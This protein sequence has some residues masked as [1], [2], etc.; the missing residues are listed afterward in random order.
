MEWSRSGLESRPCLELLSWKVDVEWCGFWFPESPPSSPSSGTDVDWETVVAGLGLVGKLPICSHSATS[1]YKSVKVTGVFLLL[2]IGSYLCYKLYKVW[3]YQHFQRIGLAR[4]DDINPSSPSSFAEGTPAFSYHHSSKTP[5]TVN[6]FLN[7]QTR[8]FGPVNGNDDNYSESE[9][10][11]CHDFT[12]AAVGEQS[13]WRQ[14]P[15]ERRRKSKLS[16]PPSVNSRKGWLLQR[17]QSLTP[18][19]LQ[20]GNNNEDKCNNRYSPRDGN[21]TGTSS[22]NSSPMSHT[23]H[24]V[25]RDLSFDSLGLFYRTRREGSIDSMSSELSFDMPSFTEQSAENPTVTRLDKLQEEIDQLKSN[26]QLMD[27]EFETVKCNRN[28]PG[29]SDLMEAAEPQE[30]Q[31]TIED[32][33]RRQSAKACFKGLYSLT[34][35]NRSISMDLSLDEDSPQSSTQIGLAQLDEE[36]LPSLEWDEEYCP[37]EENNWKVATPVSPN[38]SFKL[39]SSGYGTTSLTGSQFSC[40]EYPPSPMDNVSNNLMRSES[41]ESGAEMWSMT[42]SVS[43]PDSPMVDNAD[44]HF[45]PLNIGNRLDIMSYAQQEWT[46]NTPKSHTILRGYKEIADSL[47]YQHLRQIRG[48]NYCALRS[49]VFQTLA[50]GLAVPNGAG[51]MARISQANNTGAQWYQQWKFNGLPYSGNNI[52]RGMEICL[53]SL[54]NISALLRSSNRSTQERED[55]LSHL[56]NTDPNL[57]LHIMEAVKLHMMLAALDLYQASTN[58]EEVPLFSILMY[59][60]DTSEVPLDFMNNHLI[61]VGDSGGLEQ[62]VHSVE[63]FLLGYT[64]GVTLKVVRPSA[65]GT[66]Q[67]VCYYPDDHVSTWPQV[68]LVAEDD[69]HYNILC[70]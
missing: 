30:G 14:W 6:D 40:F 58:G 48:D 18:A 24:S 44:T 17:L 56:L 34:T 38:Q 62:D 19:N 29:L 11:N 9:M 50:Q 1:S 69:R 8:Y 68:T 26:C 23:R 43:E 66:Q 15:R 7:V 20:V 65:H 33:V 52:L 2:G 63:M 64:L 67:F 21:S 22:T 32:I 55:T 16:S 4:R 60:R 47:N 5:S 42:S 51:A 31:M 36:R 49:A 59:A 70:L 46:G 41:C 61:K 13:S 57:D 45:K 27:E 3:L 35:I 28:L 54:D 53:Q 39:D 37:D 25:S 12:A 10:S